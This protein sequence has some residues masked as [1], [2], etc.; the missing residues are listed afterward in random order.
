MSEVNHL[1]CDIRRAVKYIFIDTNIFMHFTPFYQISWCEVLNWPQCTL[2]IAP[3]VIDELDKLKRGTDLKSSRAKKALDK[4]E[5]FYENGLHIS[6]D[7]FLNIL[8]KKPSPQTYFT[9]ELDRD[10]GDNRLLATMIEFKALVPDEVLI[11]SDDVG[12]RIRSKKLGIEAIKLDKK[13]RL[14]NIE[15]LH[16]KEFRRL[17]QEL[18]EIKAAQ[19]KLTLVF[20]NDLEDRIILRRPNIKDLT[21]KDFKNSRMREIKAK[22]PLKRAV[23]NNTYL[24][25]FNMVFDSESEIKRHNAIIRRYYAKCE[26]KME[27]LFRYELQKVLSFGLPFR[28]INI[29]KST[30]NDIDIQCIFPK[31]VKVIETSKIKGPKLPKKPNETTSL[32]VPSVSETTKANRLLEKD[33]L[34]FI[35]QNG[36]KLTY[37]MDALKHGYEKDFP[38]YTLIFQASEEIRSFD[39]KYLIGASNMAAKAQGTLNVVFE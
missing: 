2:V 9:N 37:R 24:D 33:R 22:F 30:A 14:P 32:L 8:E 18:N 35:S 6:K 15:S 3:V 27:E 10:E 7:V 16:E 31:D 12:P 39:I 11:C 1:L 21:F 5:E 23:H 25:P 38:L 19:P 17:K 29:G 26:D 36:T 20:Q 28:I 34:R 13:Y 4:I